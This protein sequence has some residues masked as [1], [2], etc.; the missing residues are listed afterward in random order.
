MIYNLYNLYIIYF[1]SSTNLINNY[2][3]NTIFLKYQQQI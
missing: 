2:D 3:K 1:L